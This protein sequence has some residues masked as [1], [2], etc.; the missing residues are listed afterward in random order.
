[1]KTRQTHA[2]DHDYYAIVKDI[3]GVRWSVYMDAGG[4]KIFRQYMVGGEGKDTLEISCEV[5]H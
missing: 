4:K 2:E 3:D 1:M 5:T